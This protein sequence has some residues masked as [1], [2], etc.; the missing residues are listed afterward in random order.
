MFQLE[1]NGTES[2]EKSSVDEDKKFFTKGKDGI[3]QHESG[4]FILPLPLKD[5]NI[6]LPENREL[7]GSQALKSPET[8]DDKEPKFQKRLHYIHAGFPGQGLCRKGSN[9]TNQ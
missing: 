1:Y 3:H 5:D 9:N 8:Q 4:H 2:E 7:A 6:K